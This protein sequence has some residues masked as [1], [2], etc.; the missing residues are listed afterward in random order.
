MSSLLF[1]DRSRCFADI[2]PP[3]LLVPNC[4]Q[5]LT[6]SALY[7][8][9]EGIMGASFSPMQRAFTRSQA[10]AFSELAWLAAPRGMASSGGARAAARRKPKSYRMRWD[11]FHSKSWGGSCDFNGAISVHGNLIMMRTSVTTNRDSKHESFCVKTPW[12]CSVNML[13]SL[14]A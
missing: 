3:W 8:D 10:M 5:C 14:P 11:P 6:G 9:L 4:W 7:G 2:L 12:A 1:Q 13:Q